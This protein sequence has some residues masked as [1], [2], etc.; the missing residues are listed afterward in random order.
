TLVTDA[1]YQ[2]LTGLKEMTFG[3][4]EAREEEVLPKHRPGA[5]SF[6]DLWVPFGGEEIRAVGS[7]VK[8]AILCVAAREPAD[9]IVM[10][11]Q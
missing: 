8:V 7:R 2:Q 6:E 5:R 1:P 11:R 9:P 4:C 10:V 3:M